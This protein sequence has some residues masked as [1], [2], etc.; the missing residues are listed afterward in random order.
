[1]PN[2][3]SPALTADNIGA[4]PKVL[5]HDHLDGGVR[6]ITLIELAAQ[7]GYADM[8]STDPAELARW[9]SESAYS[10][11]LE[12]YLETFSHTTAVMQTRES[13]VRVAS[14]CVQDLAADGV[15]YAEVRFAPELHTERNLTLDEVVRAVLD[16]VAA[17]TKA[18]AAAGHQI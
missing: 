9:F 11:S 5:L 3:N 10:G 7:T 13:L 4:V 16:G 6:P 18:A 1:M 15:V 2:T 12:R 8:P 17:G 14:E